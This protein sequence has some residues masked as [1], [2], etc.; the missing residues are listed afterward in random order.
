ME[1]AAFS[2]IGADVSALESRGGTYIGSVTF[3]VCG[4]V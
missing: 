3:L 4:N 1:L 2:V